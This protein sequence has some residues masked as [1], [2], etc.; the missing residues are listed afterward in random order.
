MY[1]SSVS[2]IWNSN[3]HQRLKNS[4]TYGG[5]S[6]SVHFDVPYLPTLPIWAVEYPFLEI[7]AGYR[8]FSLM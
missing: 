4:H 8:F 6:L 3:R 7:C 1:L 5:A 2:F